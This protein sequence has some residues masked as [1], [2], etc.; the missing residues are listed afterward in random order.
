MKEKWNNL[1]IFNNV[2]EFNF[3]PKNLH[4]VASE[5]IANETAP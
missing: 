4:L 1:A 3:A 5:I 2:S